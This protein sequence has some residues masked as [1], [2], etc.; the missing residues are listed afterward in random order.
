V[1]ITTLDRVDTARN[2]AAHTW[3]LYRYV[4]DIFVPPCC[5]VCNKVE[6]WLCDDCLQ[7]IQLFDAAICPRCGRPK[8]DGQLCHMCQKSP[9]RVSPIRSAFLFEGHIRDA[10]HALKYRG[11]KEIAR[12]LSVRM[13]TAWHNYAMESDGII[14]VPLHP[15]RE[16]KR[17]Y[18]QAVVIAR[19]LTREVHIPV[20]EG[21]LVRKRNTASQTKL[22]QQERRKNVDDAFS[23]V[24]TTHIIGKRITLVDDVATTGATLD[25]CAA[26]L[27][28]SGAVSINAF[29]LARAAGETSAKHNRNSI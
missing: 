3:K 11:A 14:P 10:I 29:T 19:A 1:N 25:A 20:I 2:L 23:C 16:M 5:V 28:A 15:N 7:E 6:T 8:S 9:L 18:N 27:L 22:N 21:A 17:G 12:T 24:D 26:A 13:A 4:L